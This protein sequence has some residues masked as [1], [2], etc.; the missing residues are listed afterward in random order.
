MRAQFCHAVDLIPTVLDATGVARPDEVDG[1]AQQPLDGASLLPCIDDASA[2]APRDTQYFEMVGSRSIYHE[3]WKATT[4]H[5]G[6]QVRSSARSSRAAT[7]STTD[8]WSLF[9]LRADFSE[10]HDL[11]DAEPE[12]LRA[13]VELWW[14][15]AGRNQVLPL[16]DGFLSRAG[17]MVRPVVRL[18]ARGRALR[19]RRADRRGRAA[20]SCSAAS[21]SSRS[22]SSRA[23]RRGRDRRARRL[24]QRLG[25]VPARAAGPWRCSTCAAT[26]TGSRPTRWSAPGRTSSASSTCAPRRA[27]GRRCSSSTARALAE[28]ELARDLPFRWQ[29]GG[30]GLCV[31][32]DR[33]FPVCDDYE[34]P[35]PL[36][37]RPPPGG[38]G[39]R[40]RRPARSGTGGR[41]R[42]APR[43]NHGGAPRRPHRRLRLG[44]LARARV[45]LRP[46]RL[47]SVDRDGRGRRAVGEAARPARGRPD[48][49]VRRARRRAARAVR[50][51]QTGRAARRRCRVR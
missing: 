22:S 26:C 34:P 6:N 4:D 14:A 46:A 40:A 44:P 48:H 41:G 15:E 18:P 1:V 43:V 2:P 17:A 13:L 50:V 37:R 16:E 38:V 10:A 19:G 27:A 45:L 8:R 32:H 42:A 51:P 36:Q 39:R 24:E 21:R 28:L 9:D 5:V 11:A 12:R 3:G 33:G 7:T 23:R 29:I 35:F 49:R 47:P 30:A 31:G 25:A 20:A